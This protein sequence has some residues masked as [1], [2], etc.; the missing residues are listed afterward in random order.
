MGKAFTCP[1][2]RAE[3]VPA[4]MK[5]ATLKLERA[6]LKWRS[7]AER[8]REHLLDLYTSGR[9]RHYYEDHEFRDVMRESIALAERWAVIAPRAD[10]LAVAAVAAALPRR[11]G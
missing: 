3:K 4:S 7:L 5:P 9:W 11:V 1:V 8:R 2:P 10:E 6:A